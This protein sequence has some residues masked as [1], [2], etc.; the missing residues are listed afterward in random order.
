MKRWRSCRVQQNVF[1]F[2]SSLPRVLHRRDCANRSK[3]GS[4]LRQNTILFSTI[5]QNY[6]LL[7]RWCWRIES[8][9]KKS[10]FFNCLTLKTKALPTHPKH[11]LF[12]IRHDIISCKAWIF[13]IKFHY[14]NFIPIPVCNL[15]GIPWKKSICPLDVF[16]TVKEWSD[17]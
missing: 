17:L 3:Q 13:R 9:V 4:S 15:S 12:T 16:D 5:T 14:S 6:R 8:S 2:V 10:L 1:P 7:Q 11:R